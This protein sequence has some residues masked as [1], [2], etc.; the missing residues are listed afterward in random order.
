MSLGNALQ[1]IVEFTAT[2]DPRMVCYARPESLKTETEKDY[3][4]D[5]KEGNFR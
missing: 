4:P 1:Q 2:L 3:L 5:K